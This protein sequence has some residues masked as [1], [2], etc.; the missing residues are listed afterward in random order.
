MLVALTCELLPCK[1]KDSGVV[2]Q[3]REIFAAMFRFFQ[4]RTLSLRTTGLLLVR[5]AYLDLRRARQGGA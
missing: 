4:D 5:V 3:N 1:L 2:S